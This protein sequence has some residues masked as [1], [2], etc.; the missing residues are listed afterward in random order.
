MERIEANAIGKLGR[1]LHIPGSDFGA[2]AGFDSADLIGQPERPR[3]FTCRARQ[4]F[5]RRHVAPRET[6]HSGNQPPAFPGTVAK[7]DMV[8][9]QA[10]LRQLD[11]IFESEPME[12]IELHQLCMEIAQIEIGRHGRKNGK[13]F[14]DY[15][16][17]GKKRLWPDLADLQPEHLDPDTIDVKEIEHR[18]LVIQ[19]LETAR[20]FA[21][22][23]LTDVREADVGSILA[24]GFA[25]YTGG[26]LS[27]IDGMGAEA[28]LD[29]TKKLQKKYGKQF[30]APKLIKQMAENGETFYSRFNPYVEMEEAA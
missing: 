4:R 23:V 16:D 7:Q 22:G 11:Q 12:D 20:C 9:G 28:F 29:L 18:L 3:A 2:L 14:Y 19:A 1:M 26:T 30:K 27:Y 17:K 25:P 5:F 6:R 13:G 10:T 24:F 21:E 8:V 15:P